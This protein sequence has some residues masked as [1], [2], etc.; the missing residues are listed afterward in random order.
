[1]KTPKNLIA[2]G[3]WNIFTNK[4][5]Y[6]ITCGNCEHIYKDKVFFIDDDASSIC[7]TCKCQNVWSHSGFDE[8]YQRI[9]GEIK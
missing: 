3:L 4:K 2:N 8:D 7:P 1:M 6:V 9:L 5:K